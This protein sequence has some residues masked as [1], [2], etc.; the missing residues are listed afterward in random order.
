[1][2]GN[3]SEIAQV[4]IAIGLTYCSRIARGQISI[5]SAQI[6]HRCG[7]VRRPRMMPPMP[8]VSAMVWRRPYFFGSSKSVTVQGS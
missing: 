3:F 8:S 1:M 2:A 5:M 6:F 4:L 7:T